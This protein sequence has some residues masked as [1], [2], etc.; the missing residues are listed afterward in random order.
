MIPNRVYLLCIW[1]ALI[2]ASNAWCGDC[3]EGRDDLL[4]D[5]R[6]LVRDS[7]AKPDDYEIDSYNE[8]VK[9]WFPQNGGETLENELADEIV[10]TFRNDAVPELV[11]YLT[12]N[13]AEKI[14][15]KKLFLKLPELMQGGFIPPPRKREKDEGYQATGSDVMLSIWARYG[16]KDKV[17][18][19]FDYLAFLKKY[20]PGMFQ[21][22]YEGCDK[23]YETLAKVYPYDYPTAKKLLISW[24]LFNVGPRKEMYEFLDPRALEDAG[25]AFKSGT[26][27]YQDYFFEIIARHL[28]LEIKDNW[29]DEITKEHKKLLYNGI[30]ATYG[31]KITDKKMSKYFTTEIKKFCRNG[32]C[33]I[34]SS[35][36]DKTL[37]TDVDKK[38]LE[39]LQ[40][41]EKQK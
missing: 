23:L 34:T 11:K 41:K 22:P 19:S 4:N 8:I 26:P 14:A 13:I 30:L 3:F 31:Y 18:A 25:F 17:I 5:Y 10:S 33:G 16:K 1:F 36:F 2:I 40:E 24:G 32:R 20:S 27:Y 7:I 9:C 37:L 38:N 35:K 29:L 6:S 15:P 39:K 12:L 28:E 21:D